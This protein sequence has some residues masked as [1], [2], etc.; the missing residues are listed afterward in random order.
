MSSPPHASKEDDML[1]GCLS[2]GQ[3]AGPLEVPSSPLLYEPM[4]STITS[5]FGT[6][7]PTSGM[8]RPLPGSITQDV[9]VLE[10][11]ATQMTTGLENLLYSERLQQGSISKRRL[12][13]RVNHLAWPRGSG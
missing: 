9:N 3:T 12:R 1:L 11:K 10:R 6:D 7:A 8:P 13:V 5:A 4:T 2:W